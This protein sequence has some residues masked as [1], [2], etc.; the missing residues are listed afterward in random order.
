MMKPCHYI[1]LTQRAANPTRLKQAHPK[2]G[3]EQAD[4][5]ARLLTTKIGDSTHAT[6]LHSSLEDVIRAHQFP[7]KVRHNWFSPDTQLSLLVRD[8]F[9]NHT[10]I[11]AS[12]GG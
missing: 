2:R 8:I 1:R 7:R 9:P 5:L 10:L 4:Q 6:M 3:N 11:L 12:V